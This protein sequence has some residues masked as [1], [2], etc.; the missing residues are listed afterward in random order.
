[1]APVRCS[2]ELCFCCASVPVI[3][4]LHHMHLTP[5]RSPA[6]SSSPTESR[7]DSNERFQWGGGDCEC[8]ACDFA[9]ARKLMSMTRVMSRV[10]RSVPLIHG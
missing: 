1:M 9:P 4:M 2:S 8:L 10:K 3:E 7:G 5:T 6:S